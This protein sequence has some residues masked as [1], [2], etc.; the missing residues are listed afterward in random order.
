[1]LKEM[2]RNGICWLL[3]SSDDEMKSWSP[4]RTTKLNSDRTIVV[5]ADGKDEDGSTLLL[6]DRLWAC[7]MLFLFDLPFMKMSTTAMH[8]TI[9]VASI[10]FFHPY[11]CEDEDQ[12]SI[13]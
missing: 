8:K 13:I 5:I 4:F 3:L 7:L 10:L 1:M 9:Q 11:M 12:R 2:K 6:L